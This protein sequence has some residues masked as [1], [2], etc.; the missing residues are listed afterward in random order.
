LR[1]SAA[2]ARPSAPRSYRSAGASASQALS[3]ASS[4]SGGYSRCTCTLL[5]HCLALADPWNH[6]LPAGAWARALGLT[7]KSAEATVSRNW[8][9]LKDKKLVRTERHKRVVDAYLLCEDG[10]GDEYTRSRDYFKLPLAFFREGWHKKLS[11]PAT[12]T[13]LIALDR[14]RKEEWFELRKEPASEWFGISADTLQRGL[15][16]LRDEG[17]LAVRTEPKRDI[18]ARYGVVMVNEYRL[19]SD[20]ART[21][22]SSEALDEVEL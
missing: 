2:R 22:A 21:S 15:D 9:W 18:R 19:L 1:A 13:L 6:W 17:L 16:E 10:S 5:L 4:P 12:A 7:S 3:G 14:Q 11:L 8:R 20:F